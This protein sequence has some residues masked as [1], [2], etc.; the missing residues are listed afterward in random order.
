FPDDLV[1]IND[2]GPILLLLV[3]KLRDFDGIARRFPIQSLQILSSSGGF[4]A[5]WIFVEKIFKAGPGVGRRRLI[6]G[7]EPSRFK[8]NVSDL[9]L[10]IRRDW[11]I[12]KFV[13]YRLIGLDRGLIRT[14]FLTRQSD[15]ELRSRRV[16]A[17]CR[18]P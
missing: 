13:D 5:L 17:I 11:L 3:V 10:S 8:P 16:V 12:R 4:F 18:G 7:A 6:I 1:V 2:R 9:I 15:I 14:L